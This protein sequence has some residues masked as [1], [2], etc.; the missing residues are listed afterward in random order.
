MSNNKI[1]IGAHQTED[2][3]DNY[4]SSSTIVKRA[5][6]KYGISNFKK[7]ILFYFD[8][9]TDMYLKEKEIVNEDFVN[10]E[11]TY[12]LKTGGFGGFSHINDGSPA[13][14]EQCKAATRS[15]KN[16]Y[17]LKEN[18]CGVEYNFKN[19]EEHRKQVHAKSMSLEAIEKR[20]E[21]YKEINHQQ[22]VKN[23][24]YGK[25]WIYSDKECCSKKINKT[26]SIPKGWK[27]GRKIKFKK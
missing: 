13:H 16:R 4:M 1:Y 5:I 10:S 20:K 21:T 2:V 17:N 23:S 24:Q 14:I 27:K 22:G 19:N 6:N 12:N 11:L 25:M 3:N 8:N 15:V 9:E 26:D 18:G 7:E